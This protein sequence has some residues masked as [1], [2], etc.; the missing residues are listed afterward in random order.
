ME[1]SAAQIARL[2]MKAQL[3]KQDKKLHMTRLN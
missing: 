2:V 3:L 1:L